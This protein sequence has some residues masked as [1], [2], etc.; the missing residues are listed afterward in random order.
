MPVLDKIRKIYTHERE[1][2]ETYKLLELLLSDLQR[3]EV[4][5]D[6]LKLVLKLLIKSAHPFLSLL[7]QLLLQS[8]GELLDLLLELLPFFLFLLEMLVEVLTEQR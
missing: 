5:V 2:R 3:A 4:G 8:P 1:G 6:G 7:L